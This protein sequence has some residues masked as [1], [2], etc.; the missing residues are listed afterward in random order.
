MFNRSF[1]VHFVAHRLEKIVDSVGRF[2]VLGLVRVRDVFFDAQP[3]LGSHTIRPERPLKHAR[4]EKI[5]IIGGGGGG[6]GPIGT[7]PIEPAIE[8]DGVT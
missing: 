3:D 7:D 8:S 6:V 4:T 2:L 1:H 5:R